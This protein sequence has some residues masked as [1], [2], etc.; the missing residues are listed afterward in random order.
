MAMIRQ[1]DLETSPRQALVLNVEDIRAQAEAIMERTRSASA[2]V[3]TEAAAARERLLAGAADEGRAKGHA[4]GM[5]TGLT[6]GRQRGE[7]EAKR[8]AGERLAALEASWTAALVE[9]VAMRE[10]ML[11]ECESR[12]LEL[13]ILMGQKVARR[14]IEVDP[15]AV[16]GQVG[17]IL[18]MATRAT[19]LTLGVNPSDEGLVR[20]ALPGLL[21]MDPGQRHV[22]VSVDPGVPVGSC[23]ARCP[24]GGELDATIE[25]RIKSLVDE[26]LPDGAGRGQRPEDAAG[27]R[28]GGA[29]GDETGE[30]V[31]GSP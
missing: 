13:A 30:V 15:R 8:E 6:E 21:A 31:G 14:A 28:G 10:A 2:A 19:R 17:A 12:G 4:E 23:V 25:A 29:A 24:G 27:A 9:F 18:E 3:L 20:D 26:M 1:A 7:A 22:S 5:A 16:L 11:R